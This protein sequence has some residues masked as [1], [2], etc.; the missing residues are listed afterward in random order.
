MTESNPTTGS[1]SS[2]PTGLLYLPE[3]EVMASPPGPR[4]PAA[5]HIDEDSEH[6]RQSFTA[7][8][9]DHCLIHKGTKDT[10]WYPQWPSYTTH[11]G[12]PFSHC[13]CYMEPSLTCYANHHR[14]TMSQEPILGDSGHPIYRP[15]TR[16]T[17]GLSFANGND[18]TTY[19]WGQDE[20][21]II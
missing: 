8:F 15:V 6:T 12:G 3:N 10:T 21:L 16:P 9:D 2:P 7:Y 5:H 18:V 1:D 13:L 20:S 14:S 4:T 11:S 17:Q 19:G